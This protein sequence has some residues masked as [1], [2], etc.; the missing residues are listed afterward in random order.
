MAG[1][2][3]QVSQVPRRKGPGHYH[4]GALKQAL[5]A[6]ALKV[7]DEQ[8]LAAVTTR[9][10]AR[11]LGVSHAAPGHHFADREALLAE[12]ATEGFRLFA[13]TLAQAASA[14]SDAGER[15]VA[16]GRAYLRFA[17]D[18]PSY[19]RVMFGRGFPKGYAP[20]EHFRRESERAYAVL[21]DVVR[22]LTLA[23]GDDPTL[24][25]EL[26]FGAWSLVHGMAML[27]ID[28]SATCVFAGR[29]DF[30]A[31]GERVVRRSVLGL[32]AKG[33]AVTPPASLMPPKS[34]DRERAYEG[35]VRLSRKRSH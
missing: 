28:G 18:H 29:A 4:H 8:G 12:V 25:D 21:T 7:I 27:W 16:I 31:A 30:E 3:T 13:D 11:R 19:L 6:E 22:D 9:A 33:K 23:L 20:P 15:F 10:L 24:I 32:V 5:I 14:E 2:L 26:A 17:A 1:L 34:P 35:L